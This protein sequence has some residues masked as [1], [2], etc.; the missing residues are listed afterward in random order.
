MISNKRFNLITTELFITGRKHNISIVFIAQSYVKATKDVA[1]T[2]RKERF[3][4]NADIV[5]LVN[6]ADLEKKSSSISKKSRI[7]S[8]KR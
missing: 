6:N 4:R 5:K 3:F 8:R 7:K 1:K 2:I